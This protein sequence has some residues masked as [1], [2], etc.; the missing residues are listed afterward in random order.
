MLTSY[1][2]LPNGRHVGLGYVRQRGKGIQEG[3]PEGQQVQIGD[4]AATIVHIPAAQYAIPPQQLPKPKVEPTQQTGPAGDRCEIYPSF[5]TC[6]CDLFFV[7]VPAPRPQRGG[8]ALIAVSSQKTDCP[9]ATWQSGLDDSGLGLSWTLGRLLTSK[10][11]VSMTTLLSSTVSTAGPSCQ[12]LHAEIFKRT[13]VS[14]SSVS[15]TTPS[16]RAVGM[17]A[18]AIHQLA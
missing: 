2:Q 4:V 9:Q 18:A 16:L 6:L 10:A 14:A 12:P 17:L 8:G 1:V 7:R 5:Q 15:D 11:P 13:N 3:S